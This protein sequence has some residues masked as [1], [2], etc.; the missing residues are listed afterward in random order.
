M[1]SSSTL[2]TQ[3]RRSF[4]KMTATGAAMAIPGFALMNGTEIAFAGPKPSLNDS[5]VAVLQFLA[6]AELVESDL[7][8]QYCELATNNPSYRNALQKIDESLPDYI[9]GVFE[10]ECSHATFINAFLVATGKTSINLDP[11]AP[12]PASPSKARRTSA[13]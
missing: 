11:S 3:S 8:G 2:S 9:C 1:N 6:A 5:D 10:D 7:W 12:C 13:A 4:F